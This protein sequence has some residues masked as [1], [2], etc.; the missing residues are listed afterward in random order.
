LC[1]YV[2]HKHPHIDLQLLDLAAQVAA[3][4]TPQRVGGLGYLLERTGHAGL[5]AG[6][7]DRM[8]QI[9]EAAR[10]LFAPERGGSYAVWL[11][12]PLADTLIEYATDVRFFH[13]LEASLSSCGDCDTPA[14]APAIAAATERR[15]ELARGLAY[16]SGDRAS[17][18]SVD[19]ELMEVLYSANGR[20]EDEDEDEDEDK[21][22][23][24]E[25][26]EEEADEES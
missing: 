8:A 4:R 17:N 26:Y 7:R 2:K 11:A 15:L 20:G 19:D 12:R 24:Y 1:V 25:E 21:Y 14:I 10:N 5:T 9:K 22:E 23:E 18:I 6:E 3:G 13:T 16:R